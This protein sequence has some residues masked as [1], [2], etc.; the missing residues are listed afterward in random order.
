[1]APR[2]R[3]SAFTEEDEEEALADAAPE[4]EGRDRRV[5]KFG[6]F[7][8]RIRAGLRDVKT[9]DLRRLVINGVRI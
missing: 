7:Q 3:M 1:M 8:V 5:S 6:T 9:W 2:R 4:Q